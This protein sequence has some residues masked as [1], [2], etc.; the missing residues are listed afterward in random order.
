MRR[1]EAKR[2]HGF[3][4]VP[5]MLSEE[6]ATNPFLR[7]GEPAVIAAAEAHAGRKLADPVEVFATLREWKNR[8]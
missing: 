6:R 3:P 8:F 5:S 4:T 1:D 2:A 7:I